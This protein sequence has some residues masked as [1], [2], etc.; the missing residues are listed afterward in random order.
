MRWQFVV[1]YAVL[2]ISRS[3]SPTNP[4]SPTSL[5]GLVAECAEQRLTD[6]DR[7]ASRHVEKYLFM[8][9]MGCMWWQLVVGYAV[10]GI[11]KSKV[12]QVEQVQLV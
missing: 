9:Y 1:D 12:K 5:K 3:S 4:T 2:E 6:S 7:V 11:C 10:L 8:I